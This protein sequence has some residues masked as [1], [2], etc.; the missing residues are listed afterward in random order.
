MLR[1]STKTIRSIEKALVLQQFSQEKMTA[2]FG[3]KLRMCSPQY[4]RT[5]TMKIKVTEQGVL[6]PRELLGDSQE[7]EVIQEA[8][9]IIITTQNKTPSIWNLGQNPVECGESIL[10]I[11]DNLTSDFTKK[12]LSQL[13][14]DGA[15]E[16]DHYLYGIP[17]FI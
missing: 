14:S 5:L 3:A 4:M 16:H 6:I 11:V 10:K 17:N 15:E 9:K 1:Q 2:I 8:E 12:E 13:P 7:V